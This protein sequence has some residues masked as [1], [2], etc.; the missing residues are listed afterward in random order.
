MSIILSLL[1]ELKAVKKFFGLGM[2]LLLMSSLL[3]QVSPL[4]IRRVIDGPLSDLTNG[5][6]LD[7][8]VLLRYL[9]LF[10]SLMVFYSIG[11][12][13]STRLLMHAANKT[14][15]YLRERAYRVMQRLPISYFD[16]KPAGKIATRIVNDTETI[17]TQFYAN[18][19]SNFIRASLRIT[20][21]YGIVFLLDWRLG[22][23]LLLLIPLFYYWQLFYNRITEKPI[24]TFYEARS[25]INTQVN[26]TMNGSTIIQ[27]YHQENRIMADFE[28]LS[29]KMRQAEYKSIL[30]DSSLSWNLMELLK[31]FVIAATLTIVGYQFLSDNPLIT[32]GRLFIYINYVSILFDMM[33]N[34]VRTLPNIK[35]SLT[36]GRRLFE[37]LNEPLEDDSDEELHIPVGDVRFENVSFSYEEGKK[38]LKNIVIHAKAG[39]TVA[40]VGH[41]GSGKSSIMNLLYRFYDPQEGRIVID[42]QDTRYFSRESL[43]SHMGIVLQDPYIFTGTIASNVTMNN[44]DFSDEEIMTALKRVG[45]SDM[46]AR[47]KNG[48]HEKVVEKGSAFSSGERQL[49]AFART[50]I[51]DPKILILDEA[52]SHID[53]E[54]E[55]MIQKAMAVLKEGR[56]TFIIAHRLSTIQDADQILVLDNGEIV[57][58]G[59]HTELMANK[60][61]YA[62]MQA[63]QKTIA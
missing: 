7:D 23:F 62:Q 55:E 44:P 22:L 33:G 63:I 32:A 27:L 14:A 24:A 49:I 50:L 46:V 53:T 45:A 11:Y 30:I 16:D 42:H 40:L 37:L 6:A 10:V 54:T 34:L 25:D 13:V 26:E 29:E 3:Q 41:T 51:V 35:R 28:Q 47:L 15:A 19:L 18:L 5:K 57:E 4:I 60:G 8:V 31:N 12:Y 48:I 20:I 17:R 58:Q 21:I 61:R 2:A 38:V 39:Q 43:R 9:A 1:K 36:T 52:T 56:T 59:T